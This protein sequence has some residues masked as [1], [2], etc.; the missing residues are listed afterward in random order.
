MDDDATKKKRHAKSR[1]K[2]RENKFSALSIKEAG[3][4]SRQCIENAKRLIQAGRLLADSAFRELAGFSICTAIEEIG[5][6]FL[7][8]ESQE[9][10]FQ[11]RRD[12]GKQLADSFFEHP[13][14]LESA[15]IIWKRDDM[16]FNSL[17]RL[18][19]NT[20][21]N[22][23]AS[24]ALVAEFGSLAIP[25]LNPLARKIF[26]KHNRLLYTDFRNQRFISPHEDANSAEFEE[27]FD[28]AEKA[29]VRAELDMVMGEILFPQRFLQ[30]ATQQVGTCQSAGDT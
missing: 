1:T 28:I 9:D 7:L 4:G 25:D 23:E 11:G 18:K 17:P 10:K 21:S 15:L 3:K 24:E 6:A 5:K 26:Q 30:D 27:L 8:M 29:L 13:D 14:T 22:R 12:A 19:L 16:L 20:D 2:K